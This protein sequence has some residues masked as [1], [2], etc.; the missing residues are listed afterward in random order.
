MKFL[1]RNCGGL[2]VLALA[3]LLVGLP[4]LAGGNNPDDRAGFDKMSKPVQALA[5]SGGNQFVDVIITYKKKPGP[6]DEDGI[7]D[8]NGK[9]K[10]SFDVFKMRAARVPAARLEA[11]ARLAEKGALCDVM[12]TMLRVMGLDI[13]PDMTGTPLVE[14]VEEVTDPVAEPAKAGA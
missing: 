10:R 8:S 2:T 5:E 1:V 4:V 14:F 7:K 9:L 13:P 6:A 12:P 3:A 11:L